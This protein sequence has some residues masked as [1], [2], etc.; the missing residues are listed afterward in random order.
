MIGIIRKSL[1]NSEFFETVCESFEPI[2]NKICFYNF[3]LN[4][5]E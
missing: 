1:D 4:E 3:I 2:L 5:E